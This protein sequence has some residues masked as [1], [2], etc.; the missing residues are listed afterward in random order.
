MP[1]DLVSPSVELKNMIRLLRVMGILILAVMLLPASPEVS[2]STTTGEQKVII[3]LVEFP[4]VKHSIGITEIQNMAEGLVNFYMDQS[5]GKLQLKIDIDQSWHVASKPISYYHLGDFN[6]PTGEMYRSQ[7]IKEAASLASSN[8][9]ISK[10][11]FVLV[12]H[13]GRSGSSWA[14]S[15]DWGS[16]QYLC[17]K[18]D[19]FFCQTRVTLDREYDVGT[20][21][22]EFGHL[23]NLPDLYDYDLLTQGKDANVYVGSWDLM[24]GNNLEPSPMGMSAWCRMNVGWID[25]N[26]VAFVSVGRGSNVTLAP[27]ELGNG[28][29]AIKIP[30]T[31]SRYYIVENRLPIGY[32]RNLPGEGVLVYLANDAIGSG[33]GPLRLVSLKAF[34]LIYDSASNTSNVGFVD[35]KNNVAIILLKKIGSSYQIDVTTAALGRMPIQTTYDSLKQLATNASDSI[36]QAD[37]SINLAMREGR[38][39]GL[40]QANTL[41]RQAQTAYLLGDYELAAS[42]AQQAKRIAE[43]AKAP[44]ATSQTTS[45]TTPSSNPTSVSFVTPSLN[46]VIPAV[47]GVV[48]LMAALFLM[49]R[50]RRQSD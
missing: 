12:F 25:S 6:F 21:F 9:D 22:H 39:V 46:Y 38:T 4:D 29:L 48:I 24:G 8:F 37:A 26:Q 27:L 50:Q 16:G 11:T 3:L 36:K 33:Q 40:D 45:L 30:L 10:Y 34:N 18:V 23:L 44:A 15:P 13:A 5:Y 49:K 32:D 19:Q 20:V 41:V 28:T 31:L 7:L 2:A 17:S 1:S 47:I 43:A 14:F 42:L 35:D